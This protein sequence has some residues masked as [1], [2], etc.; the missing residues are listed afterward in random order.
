MKSPLYS[1]HFKVRVVVILTIWNVTLNWVEREHDSETG[2]WWKT[3]G[4]HSVVEWILCPVLL[5]LGV[6]CQSQS[7]HIKRI[8]NN[9]ET[10]EV[11]LTLQ[12]GESENLRWILTGEWAF[13]D[14]WIGSRQ[15]DAF[16]IWNRESGRA[17]NIYHSLFIYLCILFFPLGAWE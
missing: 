14:C 11:W 9:V 16:F 17:R 4:L 13:F 1:T 12:V 10:Q 6:R 8:I 7:E 5:S 2:A 15:G 3:C